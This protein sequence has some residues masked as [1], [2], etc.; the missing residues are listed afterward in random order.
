MQGQGG[1]RHGVQHRLG[2]RDRLAGGADLL[3]HRVQQGGDA[4][5]VLPQGVG[6]VIDGPL[7]S[8]DGAPGLVQL[9]QAVGGGV[10]A[11]F[12]V[13]EGVQQGVQAVGELVIVF[14]QLILPV[15]ELGDLLQ[16]AEGGGHHHKGHAAEGEVLGAH[17]DGEVLLLSGES[18][19][20]HRPQ[21]AHQLYLGAGGLQG[22]NVILV[23]QGHRRQGVVVFGVL[24]GAFVGNG[25]HGYLHHTGLA[26]QVLRLGRHA[27][28][29]IMDGQRPGQGLKGRRG[30]SLKI[31]VGR[32]VV[33][34]EAEG[35]DA[36]PHRG[37]RMIRQI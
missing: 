36:A 33:R 17:P 21:V 6:A 5:Q 3:R 18:Q 14:L 16:L 35:G 32:G 26:R 10:Q 30:L 12:H 25:V 15:A 19:K 13:A 2:V 24:A 4:R 34:V 28:E 31:E 29:G 1:V 8:G 27:V 37:L 7:A 22:Q 23:E 11:A 9:V 20:Q